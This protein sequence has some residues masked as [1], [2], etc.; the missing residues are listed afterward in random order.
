[1]G[2]GGDDTYVIGSNNAGGKVAG[3][4]ALEYGDISSTGG[5]RTQKVTQLILQILRVLQN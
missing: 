5:C 1:M 2:N 4:T 3:G